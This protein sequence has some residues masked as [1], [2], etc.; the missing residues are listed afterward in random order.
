MA[1]GLSIYNDANTLQIDSDY[2]NLMLV[3]KK[4]YTNNMV[5]DQE[6]V[7]FAL[8]GFG[9][10]EDRSNS[11]RAYTQGTVT[12]YGFALI[13]TIPSE[14]LGLE[15]FDASGKL[16]YSSSSKPLRVL[17]MISG[18]Y[19]SAS[20]PTVSKA[21]GVNQCAVIIGQPYLAWREGGKYKVGS[22]FIETSG[23]SV[24]LVAEA[25]IISTDEYTYYNTNLS[26]FTGEY[27]YLV[28]DVSY[29]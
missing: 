7:I 28:I 14:R 22:Y 1:V 27:N 26:K 4:T 2:R 23:G 15:V 12:V 5:I 19:L 18:S 25:S 10:L 17:D 13:D 29:Y 3:S 6:G 9:A 16:C 11:L 24:R 21:Y 20:S 8:S